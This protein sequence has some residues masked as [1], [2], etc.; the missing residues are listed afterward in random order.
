ML[1]EK[2]SNFQSLGKVVKHQSQETVFLRPNY[3]VQYLPEQDEIRLNKLVC[4][5]SH[6]LTVVFFENKPARVQCGDDYFDILRLS[7]EN[8][9]IRCTNIQLFVHAGVLKVISE[10]KPFYR[11]DLDP[12]IKM[13]NSELP[14]PVQK[15]FK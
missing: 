11:V 9:V 7:P 6:P 8:A 15:Y 13:Q 3:T 14:V 1:T 12:R 5:G 10:Q 2:Q 4:L